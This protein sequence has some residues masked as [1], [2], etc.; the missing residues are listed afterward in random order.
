MARRAQSAAELN[1]SA[2]STANKRV[3]FRT[4]SASS[5]QKDDAT[6]GTSTPAEKEE[7][8]TERTPLVTNKIDS[9]ARLLFQR[10][11]G[12]TKGATGHQAPTASESSSRYVI[13]K[14]VKQGCPT[15][16]NPQLIIKY[17]WLSS[18]RFQI[19]Y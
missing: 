18:K 7:K 19:N 3:S 9:L 13:R 6:D 14:N 1:P 11:L 8:S 17:V 16:L 4:R 15:I 12:G 5:E 10:A 2:I